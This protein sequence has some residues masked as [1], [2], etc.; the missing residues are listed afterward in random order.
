M[1]DSHYMLGGWE[2]IYRGVSVD[3]PVGAFGL[4]LVCKGTQ[5]QKPKRVRRNIQIRLSFD[6]PVLAVGFQTVIDIPVQLSTK[7]A[8]DSTNGTTGSGKFRGSGGR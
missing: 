1:S 5:I 7:S 4:D 6:A 2:N 3:T 8:C